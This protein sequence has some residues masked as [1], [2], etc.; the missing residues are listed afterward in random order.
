MV[1]SILEKY[2]SFPDFWFFTLCLAFCSVH[3]PFSPTQL[4]VWGFCLSPEHKFYTFDSF[5]TEK[6]IM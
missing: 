4:K 3:A 1:L 5:Y 2:L 6:L